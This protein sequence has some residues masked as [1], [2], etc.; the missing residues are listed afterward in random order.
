MSW[1]KVLLSE[2]S[3]IIAGQSPESRYYN[4]SGDGLP[5]FQGKA[6]FTEEFPKVRYWCTQPSKIAKPLDILLSVRA[7]V[8]P[9]NICNV[10][11]CIGRGLA[12]I[13]TGDKLYYKYLSYYLKSIEKKLAAKGNGSTFSAITSRD[14]KELQIPLPPLPVQQKIAD[15]L[16]AADALRRKDQQLLAKYD[17]LA[18]AIFIDIFGDPVRNEKG[19][20]RRKLTNFGRVQTGNTPSRAISEFFGGHIEWIKTDNILMSE[21]YPQKAKEY[22]SE[23]GLLAGRSVERD[24]ILVTCIAGSSNS[25]GN[26]ALCDRKVAFNQQINSLTPNSSYNAR[27][28]Y[29]LFRFCKSMI[30]DNTTQGMKRI[31]TKSTFESLEFISP[32]RALQDDFIKKIKLFETGFLKGRNTVQYS[33]E[34]F[35]SLIQKA[36]K[37]DLVA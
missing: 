25:I 11:S 21:I 27:F 29:Y 12:A 7:P 15:I 4:T 23:L 17:E 2:V 14:I 31:I 13:R 20:P 34:L 19:W 33:N 16:D 1:E 18:Q 24:S 8:G 26:V 35:N 32:P 10:E 36:F 6:D 3:E 28:V 5:F 9:T 37:G 30:Q 22:L